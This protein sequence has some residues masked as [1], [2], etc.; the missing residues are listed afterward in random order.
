MLVLLVEGG[1]HIKR[2]KYGVWTWWHSP[3]SVER[4][5]RLDKSIERR[6]ISLKI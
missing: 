4:S 2:N 1:F 3:T 5:H 6:E